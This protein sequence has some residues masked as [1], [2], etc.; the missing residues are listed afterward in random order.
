LKIIEVDSLDRSSWHQYRPGEVYSAVAGIIYSFGN[1]LQ[2]GA[3]TRDKSNN[4]IKPCLSSMTRR[5]VLGCCQITGKDG[6][7]LAKLITLA[8][9]WLRDV[10]SDSSPGYELRDKQEK[11][12]SGLRHNSEK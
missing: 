11:L 5:Q 6:R 12:L 7:A 9:T 2:D 8:L 1:N 4:K 10:Q 3:L